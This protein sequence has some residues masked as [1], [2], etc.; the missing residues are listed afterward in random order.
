V[1]SQLLLTPIFLGQELPLAIHGTYL[2]LW[3]TIAKEGL[4]TMSR[5]HVHFSCGLLGDKQVISG[6]RSNCD[7]FVEL[8]VKKALED[9]M[10]LYRSKNLVI[11]TEGFAKRVP[12]EYFKSVRT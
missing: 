3:D 9:G 4:K 5:N 11:L 10:K 8:D 6:M 7:L 12:L 2:S 1:D